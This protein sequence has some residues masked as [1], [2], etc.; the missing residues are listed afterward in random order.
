[1]ITTGIRD[2][3]IT[4]PLEYFEK[5]YD[6]LGEHMK[7]LMAYYEDK[8]ISG[9]IVIIYGNKTWY[10][11]GASSNEHRNLMPNYLLQWEM[12]KIALQNKSDIYDLR[13]VPGIADNSNGLYRFKKGFGAEYTE[14]IGEVYIE[15]NPLKYRLYKF[16]EKAFRNLRALKL[17]LKK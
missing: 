12:I 16:A 1:M 10:L 17:K 9:V 11:Y 6:C 7:L 14:F 2:G 8:P 5:M 15:F 3:F 13:G 4:R